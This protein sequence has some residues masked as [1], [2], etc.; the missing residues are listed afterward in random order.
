[1]PFHHLHRATARPR[2]RQLGFWVRLEPLIV[3][4]CQRIVLIATTDL[5]PLP[6]PPQGWPGACGCAAAGALGASRAG[7]AGGGGAARV[8]WRGGG[9]AAA[10]SAGS[11]G[12]AGGGA[13]TRHRRPARGP[14]EAPRVFSPRF[15]WA[16]PEVLS[17][18]FQAWVEWEQHLRLHF[19]RVDS[20][21]EN[22]CHAS[23]QART[24]FACAARLCLP[25][26]T[27]PK[28]GL[29]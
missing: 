10:G 19:S 5:R 13:A 22:T 2:P 9:L 21:R 11:A 8:V 23:S 25:C 4:G 29:I 12:G 17:T 16:V 15:A 27:P 18:C 14:G 26:P 24:P 6:P 20:N 3:L 7:A 1:M 28:Q